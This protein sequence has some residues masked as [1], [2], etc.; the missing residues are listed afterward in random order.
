MKS[1]NCKE[2]LC[3]LVGWGGVGAEGVYYYLEVLSINVHGINNVRY[4]E[5]RWWP[6]LQRRLARNSNILGSRLEYV[7]DM[8][9]TFVDHFSNATIKCFFAW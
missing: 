6:K 1:I 4:R 2:L 8:T 3:R 7:F 5:E 9:V